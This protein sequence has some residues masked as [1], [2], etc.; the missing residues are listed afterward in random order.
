MTHAQ[1]VTT[2]SSDVLGGNLMRPAIA[3]A[4][5]LLAAGCSRQSPAPA[6]PETLL[7]NGR[8]FTGSP[9][10]VAQA[11]LVRGTQVAAVTSTQDGE[12]HAGAGPRRIDLKGRL[13]IPGINDAHLHV[14]MFMPE[15][16]ALKFEN[17]DPPCATALARVKDAVRT[18]PKEKP[19]IGAIGQ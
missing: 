11:L 12:A 9:A 6:E 16:T 2:R 4:V 15:H 5:L 19:I 14:D 17:M 7:F 1:K 18:A 8:V 13:V 3:L 10:R